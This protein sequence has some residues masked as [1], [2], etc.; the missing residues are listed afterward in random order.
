M[1]I[2]LVFDFKKKNCYDTNHTDFPQQAR[3]NLQGG[4]T[5]ILELTFHVALPRD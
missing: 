3:Q 2:K 4:A 5:F 1:R